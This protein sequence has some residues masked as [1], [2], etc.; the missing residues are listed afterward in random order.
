M[1]VAGADRW[2]GKQGRRSVRGRVRTLRRMHAVGWSPGGEK[3]TNRPTLVGDT[4]LTRFCL[5]G[6]ADFTVS[7]FHFLSFFP[8]KKSVQK[9]EVGSDPR[10]G[11]F[12][13]RS[14]VPPRSPL[15]YQLENG[16]AMMKPYRE[17]VRRPASPPSVSRCV[18]DRSHHTSRASQ[19]RQTC[20][21]VSCNVCSAMA[22]PYPLHATR[23]A[24]PPGRHTLACTWPSPQCRPYTHAT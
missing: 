1:S 9:G 6:C 3:K 7:Y 16:G 13:Q 19:S 8:A 21:S 22:R 17:A 4:F 15:H 12:F 18:I 24:V 20:Q 23:Y 5:A 11:Y 2:D 14:S 10:A